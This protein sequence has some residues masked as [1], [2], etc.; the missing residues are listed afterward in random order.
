MS[1][2][3][4][5]ASSNLGE[6]LNVTPT[7]I[8]TVGVVGVSIN[9][10]LSPYGI[11]S[12]Y[13]VTYLPVSTTQRGVTWSIQSGSEY[14]E[15]SSAGILSIK[16]N[17]NQSKIV[18]RAT[19]TYDISVF[20]EITVSATYYS[21]GVSRAVQEYCDRVIADGGVLLKGTASNTQDEY[22]AHMV[23]LGTTPK[24]D[25]L[26]YKLSDGGVV[27]KLYSL[28]STYDCDNLTNVIVHDGV[29]T[30]EVAGVLNYS[31]NFAKDGTLTLT[32]MYYEGNVVQYGGKESVFV[33]GL[34][35]ANYQ[36]IIP[37]IFFMS[38]YISV[39][40]SASKSC[41]KSFPVSEVSKM[42]IEVNGTVNMDSADYVTKLMVND[43]DI[44]STKQDGIDYWNV[45]I[46]D[47][48][49]LKIYNGFKLC[50][51]G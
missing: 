1:G 2:I 36:P 21:S 43:A 22:D 47:R 42:L 9:G 46:S 10:D 11:S 7:P 6:H 24:L 44:L 29:I 25:F 18:I 33:G 35:K 51:A 12:V 19:S 17:A 15:I 45:G 40:Y 26:G 41:C 3:A 27:A 13:T 37:A 31:S 5:Y 32:K 48:S 28:D 4:I 8:E 14:A 38:N 39:Q 49:F 20:A 30:T 23:L 16:E 50:I 34:L